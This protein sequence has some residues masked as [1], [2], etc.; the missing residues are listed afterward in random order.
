[1]VAAAV[2]P[3]RPRY[4]LDF[5]EWAQALFQAFRYKVIRGGRGST[6]SWSV[7]RALIIL[8]CEGPER[9]LCTRELQTSISE[10]VHHLLEEQIDLMHL[11][12]YFEIQQAAIYRKPYPRKKSEPEDPG[13]NFFFYGIKTNPTKIKSAEGITRCWVEE[14]EKISSRSWQILIPTVRMPGSEIWITFNPDEE[15]DPTYQRFVVNPPPPDQCVTI[16]VNWDQN[17]WFHQTELPKEKDYL[18]SVDP[19]AADHVW[20]GQ[21]RKNAS[22]QIFRGKYVVEDFKPPQPDLCTPENPMWDG[23]YFGLDLG[24]ANDP[25]AVSKLWIDFKRKPRPRLY[26]EYAEG[27]IGI[28]LD[29]VP[30]LLKRIPGIEGA[31]IRADCSRPESISHISGKGYCE[32][33]ACDFVFNRE[34]PEPQCPLCKGKAKFLRVEAAEKWSGSVEDGIAW[35]KQFEIVFHSRTQKHIQEARLYSYKVDRLTGDV[36]AE[37]VDKHNHWWDADR[38]GCQP[39][40]MSTTK[41]GIWARL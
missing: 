37:V 38:Y 32:N 25:L 35:L 7:A 12:P 28:E 10:S 21:C 18:Y 19:E 31:I 41:L 29:A 39:M 1:M 5:P 26:V 3:P 16:E 6:K 24:F 13:S 33:L 22:S 20:G 11:G 4:D 14:A 30:T 17:P 15:N 23:P 2:L 8:S 40:I 9:I 27:G 36:L 34:H